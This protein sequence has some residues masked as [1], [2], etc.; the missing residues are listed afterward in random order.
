[1]AKA[2]FRFYEE[3]NDFLPKNRRK[4]DLEVDIKEKRPIKNMIERL[5]VPHTQVDLILVNGKP[6]DFTYIVQ[7]GDRISV[8]PVFETLNI[9]NV[10]RLRNIP[11]RR[12]KFIADTSLG[13]LVKLMRVLGFDVYFDVSLS[14]HQLIEISKKENRIILTKSKKVFKF[15]GLSHGMFVRDGTTVQQTK[16]IIDFLDL[17]GRANPFSRCLCCNCRLEKI[18]TERILARIPPKTKAFCNDYAYCRACDKIYWNGTHF[19]RMKKI[20]DDVL[21]LSGNSG[22][23]PLE[24]G[25]PT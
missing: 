22:D 18:S 13:D 20:V 16:E 7:K 1:M 12:T 10:T 9:E 3:L 19:I 21:G 17:K 14:F 24:D 5:G 25:R 11:L 8:Y 15:K 2:I 6:V 23:P 4:T